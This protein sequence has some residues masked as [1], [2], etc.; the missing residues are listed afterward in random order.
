MKTRN[1]INTL[2]ALLLVV[3]MQSC[4]KD[5][6]SI[7]EDSPSARMENYLN[8][9][10]ELL[11]ETPMWVMEYYPGVNCYYGGYT[12]VLK[13]TDK[14]VTVWSELDPEMECKSLYRFKADN[15]PVLSFDTNNELLHYFATPSSSSYEAMGGD[16][17]FTILDYDADK[18]TLLGKRS[19]NK[20]FLRP[21]E[22]TQTPQEYCAGVVNF[23]DNY[24]APILDGVIGDVD[25]K[26]EVDV[27]YRNLY[28]T[29]ENGEL[30]ED[31]NPA[32]TNIKV[33]FSFTPNGLHLYEPI[34]INGYSIRELFYLSN[35][36]DLT[37][38]VITFKGSLPEDYVEYDEFKGDFVMYYYTRSVKVTLVPTEDKAGFIMKGMGTPYGFDF[39]VYVKYNKGRGRLDMNAQLVTINGTNVNLTAWGLNDGGYLSTDPSFGVQIHKN[40]ETGNYDFVDN[41]K[42]DDFAVDSFLLWD[43]SSGY[44]CL[45]KDAQYPYLKYLARK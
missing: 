14:D 42:N 24:R 43:G 2:A 17:E 23:V 33:A 37:N 4:L 25:V 12:Y 5:Q 9:V 40:L 19:Q 1:I 3:P 11:T 18:I 44:Q 32:T 39:D 41:G 10:H 34:E 29:Y 20:Y 6:E 35:Y 28:F 16:F 45:G 15:G 8:D 7:F 38:G 30:D 22:S 21:F 36:N 13:F 31:G 27:D 26:G